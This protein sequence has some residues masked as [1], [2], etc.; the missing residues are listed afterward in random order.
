MKFFFEG[1]PKIRLKVVFVLLRKWVLQTDMIKCRDAIASKKKRERKGSPNRKAGGAFPFPP[2]GKIPT[3][4]FLTLPLLPPKCLE[5]VPSPNV[6]V[7]WKFLNFVAVAV[8][9]G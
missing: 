7:E 1:F 2:S 5:D 9:G 3:F 6:P 4:F 8:G